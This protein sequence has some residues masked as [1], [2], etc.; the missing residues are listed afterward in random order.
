[1]LVLAMMWLAEFPLAQHTADGKAS[2]SSNPIT[3]Y[4]FVYAVGL[5]VL[6]LTYAGTPGASAASGYNCPLSRRTAG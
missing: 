2:G 1:V 4:H 3:D 6:A 5:V